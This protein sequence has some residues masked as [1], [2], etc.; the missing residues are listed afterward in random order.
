MDGE[1]K[2][3]ET[4]ARIIKAPNVRTERP[5]NVVEREKV[6]RHA[7]EEAA[8]ILR[9]ARERE[10]Q[11]LTGAAEEA[12]GILEAA[13]QEAEAIKAKAEEAAAAAREA[14]RAEGEKQGIEQGVAK[15]R[16][17]A[18]ETLKTLKSMIAEGQR[19][20]EGMF[21]DNE[22]EIRRLVCEIVSRVV[23]KTIEDD[24]ETA[25]RVAAECIRHAADRQ[26]VRV[27]TH[28]DDK[29]AVEAWAPEYMRMFDD[30]ETITIDTDPR[31]R[32]GG[33]L[34]ETN[35][36]GVDGRAE[37]QVEILSGDL[38]NP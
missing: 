30:I 9:A 37:K 14:A 8:D 3:L 20:L 33:V 1:F 13:R 32:R 22:A 5:Y 10:E 2:P 12:E 6:I 16:E 29:A 35:A 23:Q 27:L 18:S 24:N 17:Q 28:P 34:I 4:M 11:I 7:E 15:G 31:V 21:V 25:A 19:I 26:T 36:G 38:T